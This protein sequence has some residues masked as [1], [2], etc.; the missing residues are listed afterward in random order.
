[1][2]YISVLNGTDLSRVIYCDADDGR[3]AGL[4]A[5]GGWELDHIA[6]TSSCLLSITYN[7]YS[8]YEIKYYIV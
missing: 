8:N 7:V 1:M 5:R 2:G 3:G 6:Y 4:R